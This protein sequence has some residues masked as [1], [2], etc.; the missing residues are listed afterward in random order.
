MPSPPRRPRS[1]SAFSSGCCRRSAATTIRRARRRSRRCWPAFSEPETAIKRTLAGVVVERRPRRIRFYRETGRAGLPVGYR[2]AGCRRPLGSSLPDRGR[3]RRSRGPSVAALGAARP[4]AWCGR[5]A[6]PPR[7]WRRCRRSSRGDRIVAVPSLGWF[8]PGA[9]A[10]GVVVSRDG[11][12][13]AR[14]PAAL[15]APRG[16]PDR[17]PSP[18]RNFSMIGAESL[19]GIG[20]FGTYL[21]CDAGGG[22]FPRALKGRA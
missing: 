5:S 2:P 22:P 6:F 18:C 10:V 8:A 13:A 14:Q 4:P 1:A 19:V 9:P 11:L 12:A 21:T 20:T 15:P 16:N 7:R 3:C 17:I